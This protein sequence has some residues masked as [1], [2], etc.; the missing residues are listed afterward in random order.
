MTTRSFWILSILALVMVLG[1]LLTIK[2]ELIVLA[3]IVSGSFVPWSELPPLPIL[4]VA[5]FRRFGLEPPDLL[6]RW[7]RWIALPPVG[8]AYQEL[9]QALVIVRR[10]PL[11]AATPSERAAL[12]ARE[13]PTARDAAEIVVDEYQISIYGLEHGNPQNAVRAGR[14]LRQLSIRTLL[15]RFIPGSRKTQ[16]VNQ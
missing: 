1:G 9:N 4:L 2:S 11:P 12:L 13:I 7:A 8:R 5:G 10:P 14:L 16:T 3:L 6:L 15:R